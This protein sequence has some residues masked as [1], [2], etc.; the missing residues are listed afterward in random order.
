MTH[1]LVLTDRGQEH[2]HRWAPS[3]S[4]G[5]WV[6]VFRRRKEDA[7][8]LH[9]Q[10]KTNTERGEKGQGSP[11][12]PRRRRPTPPDQLPEELR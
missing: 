3:C 12:R 1:S 5:G 2:V 9:R 7:V 8:K 11:R 4:C 10:H 6:G